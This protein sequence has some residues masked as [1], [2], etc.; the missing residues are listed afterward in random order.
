MLYYGQKWQRAGQSIETL[1]WQHASPYL[2]LRTEMTMYGKIWQRAGQYIE[3]LYG[4]MP[5]HIL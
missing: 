5:V 1:L 4:N 3:T 2:I